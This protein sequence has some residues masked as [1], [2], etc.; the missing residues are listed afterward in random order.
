MLAPIDARPRRGR[1]WERVSEGR[2]AF[3]GVCQVSRQTRVRV[4]P[5]VAVGGEAP[6]H[7]VP[8]ARFG[9]RPD[10]SPG[11]APLTCRRPVTRRPRLSPWR[12]TISERL[13][14]GAKV[15]ATIA[16]FSRA[17]RAADACSR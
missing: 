9:T 14:P 1:A 12:R 17:D 3:A 7:L 10:R 8:L 16:A 11:R 2:S 6:H 4:L 5:L 15:S 13:A